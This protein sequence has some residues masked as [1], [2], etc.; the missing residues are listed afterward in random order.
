M[1]GVAVA[2]GVDK[3]IATLG[4][5]GTIIVMCVIAFF[6]IREVKKANELTQKSVDT[7]NTFT[8]NQIKELKSSTAAQIG[9]LSA[10]TDEQ[11]RNLSASVPDQLNGFRLSIESRLDKLQQMS[12][13]RDKKIEERLEQAEKDIKYL[14]KD[15]VTK[16]MLYRETEGWRSEIQLVRNEIN[17]LPFEILKLTEGRKNEK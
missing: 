9:K 11:I 13:T 16:E 14:G 4:M 12:D 3:L 8:E 2:S 10:S 5:S 7:L 15:M 1:E 6:V 17:R